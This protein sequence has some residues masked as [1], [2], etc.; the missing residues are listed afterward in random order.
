MSMD[1]DLNL[2]RTDTGAVVCRHCSA[3]V[4]P[5]T[6]R[7]LAGALRHERPSTEAGP[8]VH[9]D[10]ARFTDRRIVLRQAFC[11]GCLTVLATEIVPA[12]EPNYRNWSLR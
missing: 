3:E 7:P 5:S 2:T 6:D 1:I 10:P 8:G 11:P 12:D 9:A 4:G